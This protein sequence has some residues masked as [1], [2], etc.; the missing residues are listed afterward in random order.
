MRRCDIKNTKLAA[1]LSTLHE[2]ASCEPFTEYAGTRYSS[3]DS[4]NEDY[5]WDIITEAQRD[6]LIGE[7]RYA[8]ET[9]NEAVTLITSILNLLEAPE[10]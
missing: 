2:L 5:G 7:L 8:A 10:I 9:N 6:A 4:I 3:E 1:L